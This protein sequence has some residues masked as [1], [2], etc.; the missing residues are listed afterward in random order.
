MA[1]ELSDQE[2]QQANARLAA[3]PEY[4]RLLQK[5]Q[6]SKSALDG[7]N[8]RNWVLNNPA[9]PAGNN[10]DG[11]KGD[12]QYTVDGNG[13]LIQQDTQPG[14]NPTT[15]AAL[16]G[17]AGGG[18]LAA[19]YLAGAF[20]GGGVS[21]TAGSEFAL[22]GEAGIGGG[23]GAGGAVGAA[24]AAGGVGG[25]SGAG[26]AA[27]STPWWL[28]A[29]KAAAPMIPGIVSK[30]SGGGSGPGGSGGSGLDPQMQAHMDTLMGLS[31]RRL[32]RQEPVHE[33]AMAMAQRMAPNGA[34]SPRMGNLIS[35]TQ[36]SVPTQAP[37]NPQVSEAIQRLMR[38]R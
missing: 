36:Q 8:L 16:L 19:P 2:L 11:S 10:F 4:Q 25:A 18:Y 1:K 14:W 5:Y 28:S 29:A 22:A 31:E 3:H 15:A 7:Q 9:S 21:T 12:W 13:K 6:M 33:A 27:S 35:N 32:Q 34:N 26:A 17:A 24:G 23:T 20:G 38:T 30:M 37:M